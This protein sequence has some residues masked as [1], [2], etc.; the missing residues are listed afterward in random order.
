MNNYGLND[1]QYAA[2]ITPSPV[3]LNASA[4][5]GKTKTLIAKIHHLLDSGAPVESILAITFTNKAAKEMRERLGGACDVKKM[6]ISTIH[7]MCVRI[8]RK[9]IGYTY[10]KQPFSIYD[11]SDQMSVVKTIVK[12]NNLPEDPY[13]YLSFISRKKSGNAREGGD[14]FELVYKEYQEILKQNNACDFDDLQILACDCLQ[15]DE[16]RSFYNN[17]WRH[18]LVDEFQD[19]STIQFKLIDL[20]YNPLVTKTLWAVGDYNQCVVSGTSIETKEG[21]IKVEDVPVGGYVL[22]GSG[23]GKTGYY[24]IKDKFCKEVSDTKVVT[25]KT[26]KGFTLTT[27]PDH[28]YFAG[29]RKIPIKKQYYVYLMYRQDLGYRIG[30]TKNVRSRGTKNSLT[31]GYMVRCNQELA[32]AVWILNVYDSEKEA[33]Y[34]EHFYSIKYGI[35]TWVFHISYRRLALAYDDDLIKKLYTN[36]DTAK[37]ASLLLKDLGLFLE[38]PHHVPKCM[39]I[40]RRRNFN[41]TLCADRGMHRFSI[42]GS[43]INDA[44]ILKKLGLKVRRAKKGYRLESSTK[45]LGKIYSIK[46]EIEKVLPLNVIEHGKFSDFY[47]PFLPASHLYPGML[48]FV[49]KDGSVNID[50]I[51]EVKKESYTG[52]IYDLN[53]S[54]VHNF[55][56]NGIITHNSIY[57]FRNARPENINDFIKNYKANVRHLTYNY[58]SCSEVIAHANKFLQFGKPMVPKAPVGGKISVTEF[59]SYEEEAEQIARALMQM[60]NYQGTAIIY[61]VNTRSIFFE[62]AFAKYRIPY[63]VVN[64]LAFF[65]RRVSKDLLA[66]LSAANNPDDRNSLARVINTPKR[67]FGDV[68]KT[69]LLKEG[70]PYLEGIMDEVPLVKEFIH[71]LDDIRGMKPAEAMAEYLNR[72]GYRST[73]EKDSDRYMVEALQDVVVNYDTVEDLILA[74]S[75]LEQDAKDGVNLITAHGS[76]GL[77]YDRVFVV[78]VESG[79]WPHKNAEDIAEENRLFYVACTRAKR[80]LNISYAKMKTFKGNPIEMFPSP[81]FCNSYRH[82][83]GQDF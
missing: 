25:V 27:T 4:G 77:E 40:R 54:D 21:P 58:R 10:L 38:Y 70:R 67:G 69:R 36:L 8:I 63:K 43:D 65:Q 71:L 33:R 23:R 3:Y 57:A 29:F 13:E 16:C 48:C 18:I 53:I 37:G 49:V 47:L 17:L 46:A 31:N 26:S 52:Q 6:Q 83:M 20:L 14:D 5:A 35:P 56:G 76:K 28:I 50:E 42:S 19:T 78:G 12:A 34:F 80:Y 74:S 30:Y 51:V 66:A 32:D 24:L 41:I 60:G 73:I 45:D 39:S 15:H 82:I 75:F 64:E 55:I 7:S 59:P 81:L 11:G 79:L 1:E 44:V 68:K 61:R 72:S 62:Q 22:S 2:V 9:Y